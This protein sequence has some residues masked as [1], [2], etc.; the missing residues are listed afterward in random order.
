M[1]LRTGLGGDGLESTSRWR[2]LSQ[3]TV[4]APFFNEAIAPADE[5]R[6]KALARWEEILAPVQWHVPSVAE[7]AIAC[8]RTAASHILINRDGPAIQPGPRR[9]TRSWVRDCV[10]MGAAMAK[11]ERPHVLRDFL[12]WYVQFQHEDGY[13]PCVVDR[14]GVDDL[15]E[16]DS[17][18]QLIW[19]ICEV[20]RNEGNM[21]FLKSMWQPVHLAAEYLRRSAL[22]AD[23]ARIQRTR[24]LRIAMACCRS[25]PA[26]RAIWR[27]RCIPTGMISGASAAWKRRRNWPTALGHHEDAARWRDEAREFLSRRAASIDRVI[28]KQQLAYIPG[29]VEWADFDPTATSNAIAQLDF[30]DDLPAGPLHQMLETYLDRIPAEAPRGNPLAQLHGL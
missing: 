13:V 29:S 11:V 18:G 8:F 26:T 6:D 2:R 19:G 23:D 3:V 12:I 9:Y 17:H 25:P 30:A 4:S 27:I 7:S 5:S 24:A 20:F 1:T 14:D 21:D 16:H 28:E 10:I 22:A 15:V